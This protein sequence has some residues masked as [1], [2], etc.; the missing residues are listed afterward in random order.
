MS[1]LIGNPHIANLLL[2]LSGLNVLKS[3]L[4]IVHHYLVAAQLSSPVNIRI[5]SSIFNKINYG[6]NRI[7]QCLEK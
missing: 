4:I 6:N 2:T 1:T 5:L 3:L 7:E